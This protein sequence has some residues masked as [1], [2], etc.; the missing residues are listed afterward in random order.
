MTN[1]KKHSDDLI[2]AF[3]FYPFTRTGNV[4]D[5]KNYLIYMMSWLNEGGQF[6]IFQVWDREESL[7][8]NFDQLVGFFPTW[9]FATYEMPIRKIGRLIRNR[10]LAN[11]ISKIIQLALGVMTGRKIAKHILITIE[12]KNV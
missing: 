11:L 10:R 2:C 5:H 8:V 9:K 6:V 1:Q 12:N 4:D 7:S 3:E